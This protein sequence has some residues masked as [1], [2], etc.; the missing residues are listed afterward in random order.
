MKWPWEYMFEYLFKK[1]VK[2]LK[3]NK[4]LNEIIEDKTVLFLGNWG[5]EIP[6][7]ANKPS[8]HSSMTMAQ[9]EQLGS[10]IRAMFPKM[11]LIKLRV[12]NTNSMEPWIDDNCLILAEATNSKNLGSQP[13]T[14]GDVVVY[15]KGDRLIIHRISKANKDNDAFIITGDNNI[16]PDGW[17]PIQNIKYRVFMIIYTRQRRDKD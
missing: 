4:R 5:E 13:L 3:E 17:V 10:N 7:Q 12:S 8:N 2:L 16:R 6:T 1:Q 11:K 9:A 14:E 15:T